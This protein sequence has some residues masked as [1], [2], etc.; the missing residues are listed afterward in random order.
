MPGESVEVVSRSG[1]RR[2]AGLGVAV[3]AGVV[4]ADSSGRWVNGGVC[5]SAGS[6]AFFLSLGRC[7]LVVL[8]YLGGGFVLGWAF[9]A[10][11]LQCESIHATGEKKDVVKILQLL[12]V[13]KGE[14]GD[15]FMRNDE[16]VG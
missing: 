2:G 3:V 8:C 9:P 13:A 7:R 10:A 5:R 14:F 11:A 6:G 15:V 1:R 16:Y 12:S 4:V